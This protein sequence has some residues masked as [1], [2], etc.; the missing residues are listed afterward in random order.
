MKIQGKIRFAKPEDIP[1]IIQLCHLHAAYEEAEYVMERKAELLKKDLFETS[2]KLYCLVVEYDSVLL[3][4]AT[5]MKQYATWDAR[6]YIYMDCLFIR[7]F[8]RGLGLGEK[9]I[10]RIQKEATFLDCELIQWQTPDFN[11]KAMK[12]YR[13]IGAKSK[14]KERFFLKTKQ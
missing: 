3:G 5:Y 4:Y 13:R 1:Q 9:L 12:F 2:P 7:E 11:T 8:A 14:S 6:E 10:V